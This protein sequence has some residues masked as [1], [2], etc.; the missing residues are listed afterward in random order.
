MGRRLF[1]ECSQ[2][3]SGGGHSKSL[4][5]GV[6]H[7]LFPHSHLESR[8]PGSRGVSLSRPTSFSVPHS[9]TLWGSRLS[10][11]LPAPGLCQVPSFS[12][13]VY[14]SWSSFLFS[15]EFHFLLECL[16]MCVSRH[17]LPWWQWSLVVRGMQRMASCGPGMLLVALAFHLPPN[18]VLPNTHT[19]MTHVH[20]LTLSCPIT[21]RLRHISTNTHS[22]QGTHAQRHR[23]I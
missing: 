2:F 12:C 10:L 8:C 21:Y 9:I 6:F 20:C 7:S 1:Q 15:L 4:L 16:G 11:L 17:F 19:L 14:P 22:P 5:L 3:W 23:H 13:Q 18:I